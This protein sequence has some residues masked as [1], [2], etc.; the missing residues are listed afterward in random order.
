MR[1]VESTSFDATNIDFELL[2]EIAILINLNHPHI[3]KMIEFYYTSKYYYI[4]SEHTSCG[5]LYDLV[6]MSSKI[7]EDQAAYILY[8]ILLVV[9]YLHKH[10]VIYDDLKLENILIKS[11]RNGLYHNIKL[12]NF[13]SAIIS[14]KSLPKKNPIGISFYMA[15]ETL[16]E[17]T[18]NEKCDIWSCGIILFELLSFSPPFTG[19][20]DKE[21]FGRIKYFTF[22]ANDPF[23]NRNEISNEAKDLLSKLLERDPEKRLSAEM[24][25]KH[26]L[27]KNWKTREKLIN[28]TGLMIEEKIECL[29]KPKDDEL[30]KLQKTA[31]VLIIN[32]IPQN[33]EKDIDELKLII[34]KLTK[35]LGENEK[36]GPQTKDFN[37]SFSLEN[38]DRNGNV[39]TLK[40]I[41]EY[42]HK[43]INYEQLVSVLINQDHLTE[44]MF[45]YAFDFFDKN[46][47][48]NIILD[49]F[50][51][52]FRITDKGLFSRINIELSRNIYE[53]NNVNFEDFKKLIWRFVE[54]PEI[55]LSDLC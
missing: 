40:E 4:I 8:Q 34:M 3:L 27:F 20:G 35:N 48:N 32:T 22:N 13:D 51:D 25:L 30:K 38:H 9:Q 5:D 19:E 52:L 54:G 1:R 23:L 18:Y 33:N 28:P 46:R 55:S 41:E 43:S 17:E 26:N 37:L 16:L 15:P 14:K 39:S 2:N 21:K 6:E 31:I 12:F 45:K 53:N 50:L 42:L 36:K 47:E 7:T 24:A 10:E 44:K 11:I 49:D 29:L